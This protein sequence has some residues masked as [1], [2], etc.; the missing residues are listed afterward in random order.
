VAD[1][2]VIV[3]DIFT[4]NFTTTG[5]T[6]GGNWNDV[7]VDGEALGT[8]GFNFTTATLADDL[9]EYTSGI[10]RVGVDLKLDKPND[11]NAGIGGYSTTATQAFNF[12]G[13]GA[14]P[15]VATQRLA[16][17]AQNVY[18]YTFSGLDD[19]LTY[20]FS[21]L[22]SHQDSSLDALDWTVNGVAKTVDPDGDGQGQ[23]VTWTSVA[24]DGS[25]NIDIVSAGQ[26]NQPINAMELVVVPEPAT[27][28]L[29][30]IGGLCAL[31]RHR[32]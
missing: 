32:R 3:G 23:V 26:G 1:A 12:P 7:G 30:A 18:T 8:T 13:S 24:T 11:N 21:I 16:Y 10:E 27:M 9:I 6:A 19:S 20:T 2:G 5:E 25:G 29:L 4:V 28:S 14:I 22:A 15:A 17:N 31:L